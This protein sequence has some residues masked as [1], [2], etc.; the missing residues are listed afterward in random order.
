MLPEFLFQ[1]IDLCVVVIGVQ[2]EV[3]KCHGKS[4]PFSMATILLLYQ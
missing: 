4:L 2:V 1:N 3:E